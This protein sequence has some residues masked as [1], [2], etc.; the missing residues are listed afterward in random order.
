MSSEQFIVLSKDNPLAWALVPH[1]LE[2]IK[3]FSVKYETD[4]NPE[5]L[6]DLIQQ[7]F[8]SDKPL[9]L[10]IVAYRPGKGVF[11]HA[12]ACIDDITGSRFVTIMQLE[13]DI[14]FK[15]R[16]EVKRMWDQFKVWGLENGATEARIVT[17]D[18]N[19]HARMFQRYHGFKKHRISMRK[20]LLE[21]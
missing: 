6:A 14:P 7:H 21:D 8:V 12:L 20:S 4:T 17:M 9:L 18:D 10:V 5:V 15:D 11:A 1:A 19:I 2:R 16:A 3:R 13:T